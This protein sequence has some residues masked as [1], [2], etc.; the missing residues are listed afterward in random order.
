MT[1]N[2]YHGS[3]EICILRVLNHFWGFGLCNADINWP[4]R[5]LHPSNYA[6]F[7]NNFFLA[8]GKLSITTSK[9]DWTEAHPPVSPSASSLCLWGGGQIIDMLW[10]DFFN[11]V[12]STILCFW[13]WSRRSC[14]PECA[15]NDCAKR[16]TSP[17]V[18][19]ATTRR[20]SAPRHLRK[21]PAPAFAARTFLIN[22]SLNCN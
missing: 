1:I 14:F 20:W 15:V 6:H 8:H 7:F 12:R 19:L 17:I 3:H 4:V 11:S 5:G 9:S 22:P 18:K 13:M 21:F 2:S 10:F 16:I